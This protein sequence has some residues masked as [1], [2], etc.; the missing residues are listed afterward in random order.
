MNQR[1]RDARLAWKQR[2]GALVG[3]WQRLGI[4]CAFVHERAAQGFDGHDNGPQEAWPQPSA[5]TSRS[6]GSPVSFV[7]SSENL[8]AT[9]AEPAAPARTML[10]R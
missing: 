1:R 10:L 3:Q 4:V 9:E 8:P 5:G 7:V 2:P 6:P